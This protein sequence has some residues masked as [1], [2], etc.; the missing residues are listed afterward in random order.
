ME[1]SGFIPALLQALF[2]LATGANLHLGLKPPQ[3][4]QVT[5]S[6]S[7]SPTGP[8][9][10]G[11]PSPRF[12]PYPGPSSAATHISVIPQASSHASSP[13][14]LGLISASPSGLCSVATLL[15]EAVSLV[16]TLNC[17]L[18][19][20]SPSRTSFVLSS[21]VQC[22]H[23]PLKCPVVQ[24][25]VVFMVC[26]TCPSPPFTGGSVMQD[27]QRC[28]SVIIYTWCTIGTKICLMYRHSTKS[29]KCL[30][31]SVSVCLGQA[32]LPR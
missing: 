21:F 10:P 3:I 1:T 20:L 27:L 17:P 18:L 9:R 29:R 26:A 8:L 12:H 22:H 24:Q 14:I 15:M 31:L 7:L 32:S 16:E 5:C 2:L 19:L 13:S 4:S 11:F 25:R 6:K 30:P 23:C 28:V